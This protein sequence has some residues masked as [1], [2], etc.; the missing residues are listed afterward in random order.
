MGDQPKQKT[1]TGF[2]CGLE[3]QEL[4][5]CVAKTPFTEAKCL[6]LLK[7]LRACVEK[8]VSMVSSLYKLTTCCCAQVQPAMQDCMSAHQVCCAAESH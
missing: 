7:K 8:R 6:P 2:E 5:N 1:R 3:A 4:L